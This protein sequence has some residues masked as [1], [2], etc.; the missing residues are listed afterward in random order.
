MEPC[1]GCTQKAIELNRANND[2]N[3][4]AQTLANETKE[5]VG[6]YTDEEGKKR[7]AVYGTVENIFERIVSPKM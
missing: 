6:I 2:I 3:D 5:W 7:V 1:E 4:K